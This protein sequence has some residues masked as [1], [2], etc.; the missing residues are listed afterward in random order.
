MRKKRQ[1]RKESE[2]LL[3]VCEGP[4]SLCRVSHTPLNRQLALQNQS[5]TFSSFGFRKYNK[6]F[7][8]I[9][10]KKGIFLAPFTAPN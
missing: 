10:K 8:H 4:D 3:S 6:S 2:R 5:G 1:E 7:N 9:K